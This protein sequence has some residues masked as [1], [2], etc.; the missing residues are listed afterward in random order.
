MLQGVLGNVLKSAMGG[1]K[2][3]GLFG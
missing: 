3:G 1:N 2:G